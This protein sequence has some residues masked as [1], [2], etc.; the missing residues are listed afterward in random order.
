MPYV[1]ARGLYYS[2]AALSNAF[3]RGEVCYNAA[4]NRSRLSHQQSFAVYLKR[5]D[6]QGFKT[7]AARTILEFRPASLRYWPERLESNVADAVR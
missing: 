6:I 2:A 3:R 1:N 5:L 7:F 4:R